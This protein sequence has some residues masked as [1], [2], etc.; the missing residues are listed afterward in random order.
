VRAIR[1]PAVLLAALLAGTAAPAAQKPVPPLGGRVTDLTGTLT[2]GQRKQLENTLQAFESSKG[3]QVVVL[4]VPSTGEETI[5][6]FGIR[7][8][9]QWKI[10][11]SGV[12]DG[13]I[14]LVAKDDR[15][16]RIEVG[17]G[18]EGA[19]P[20]AT[21]SRIINE[22]ITPAFRNGNFF[23]G[24]EAGVGAI[25]K[26]VGGEPLPRRAETARRKGLDLGPAFPILFVAIPAVMISMGGVI[27]SIAAAA[28]SGIGVGV[29]IYLVFGDLAPSLVFGVVV[30]FFT[31]VIA[32][33]KRSSGRFAG[34]GGH[35][36]GGSSGWGGGSGGG[37][38][39]GGGGSFGGGGASGRW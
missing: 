12:D 23:G 30:F 36:G 21:A 5:E 29:L 4:L 24:I 32:S 34:R 10:G 9:D 18:L 39:S 33:A 3:S 8:A 16:L 20:D 25:I 14:L 22:I 31:L 7:V 26:V 1:F 2:D 35:W 17:R 38:F 19:L 37:G 11:R 15:A 13:V 28:I 6:Q 27:G